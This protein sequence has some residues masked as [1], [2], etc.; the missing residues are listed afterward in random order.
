[1]ELCVCVYEPFTC[2]ERGI[3]LVLWSVVWS[4]HPVLGRSRPGKAFCAR[5]DYSF[6]RKEFHEFVSEEKSQCNRASDGVWFLSY[7]K[8][9]DC[10]GCCPK[11]C[12][13]LA[14]CLVFYWH[15]RVYML[16]GVVMLKPTLRY[17][18]EIVDSL[19]R[20]TVGQILPV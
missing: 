20:I 4:G 18:E 11:I 14:R 9:I 3:S 16:F 19:F 2:M 13:V 12:T 15:R 5:G 17:I 6:L 7:W 10:I 1:M 8:R